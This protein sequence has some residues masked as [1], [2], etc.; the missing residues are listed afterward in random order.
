MQS[1]NEL[2]NLSGSS[3]M[4]ELLANMRERAESQKEY[5]DVKAEI[6][7]NIGEMYHRQGLQEQAA[8]TFN[9]AIETLRGHYGDRHSE[10]GHALTQLAWVEVGKVSFPAA[11]SL[12]TEALG[13]QLE[14]RGR[15]S[16]QYAGNL[17]GLAQVFLEKNDYEEAER[18]EREALEIN[19]EILGPEHPHVANQVLDLSLILMVSNKP[20]EAEK[21]AQQA[22]DIRKKHYGI[23]HPQY[24]FALKRLAMIKNHKGAFEEST[25]LFVM[26]QAILS[27]TLGDDHPES[28]STADWIRRVEERAKNSETQ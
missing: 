12:F 1:L 23:N 25:E 11:E 7:M 27:E 10:V 8:S 4:Q 21:Y 19:L 15:N 24:A 14:T 2:N 13:I 26:T 6:L 3:G 20:E 16:P 5:P 18:L 17:H 9:A 28:T 22:M